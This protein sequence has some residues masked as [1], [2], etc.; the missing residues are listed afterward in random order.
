MKILKPLQAFT[1]TRAR[2]AVTVTGLIVS[3]LLIVSFGTFYSPDS[4]P[5]IIQAGGESPASDETKEGF[6]TANPKLVSDSS[7][8]IIIGTVLS[9]ETANIYPRRDG[10]VEDVLVDIGDTVKKN[11]VVAILLPK[12]V[13][14]LSS[15]MIAEKSAVKFQAEADYINSLG[16]AQESVNKAQQQIE[17]KKSA[18][19]VA[20]NEQKSLLQKFS[21]QSADV[22]QKLE[23]AFISARRARQLIE[24]IT[25]GSN[26]RTGNMIREVDIDK[27]LGLMNPETRYTV[28]FAFGEIDQAENTYRNM[29]IKD[30]LSYIYQL[31]NAADDALIKTSDMLTS[32][33]TVHLAQ[34]GLY[35]YQNITDMNNRIIAAQ[36]DILSSKENFE[37]SLNTFSTTIASEPALYSAWKSGSNN[38]NVQS[39]K[40]QMLSAQL[41]TTEQHLTFVESQQQQMTDK[42]QNMIKI[43]D[44]M[45]SAQ[46]A[47][48]GHKE[49]RSPFAGT[50]SKRFIEVGGMAMPSISAFE[51]VDVQTTLSKKAKKEIKFGLPERMLTSLEIGDEVEFLMPNDDNKTYT[52]QVSRKSPQ[53]DIST[54]T[55]TV[56]AKIPDELSIPH[57]SSV[58]VRMSDNKTPVFRIPSFSVKREGDENIIWLL[59]E[60]DVPEKVII[61]VKSEDG[62]FAEVTG[63]ITTESEIILDP[64]DFIAKSFDESPTPK[65][66]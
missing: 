9:H 16:V 62:E 65:L 36:H 42:S 20:Q 33:P 28:S 22:K 46:Y 24:Q 37:D 54:Q 59:G 44:S 30:Q 63:D 32:T 8:M 29:S 52:A 49:I 64:P 61:N 43:A 17:E 1:K 6:T 34:P 23:H 60:N 13:E 45:L 12:G 31:M 25:L 26:T 38:P 47:E 48:S 15:A 2:I 4:P 35:T 55:I 27:Q 5:N 40:V 21:Q 3:A 7:S 58:R 51:L 19:A 39:N 66:Q 56:Q 18:L 53:V 50:V 11:Q 41:G 14:G 57:N 10:I